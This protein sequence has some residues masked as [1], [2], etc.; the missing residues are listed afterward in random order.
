MAL[1]ASTFQLFSGIDGIIILEPRAHALLSPPLT[2][3]PP[4]L[5]LLQVNAALSPVLLLLKRLSSR[6]LILES[7][8]VAPP[9]PPTSPSP[10]PSDPSNSEELA[11]FL[12]VF[13]AER[14]LPMWQAQ[15]GRIGR[16]P[17]DVLEKLLDAMRDL[18][19]ALDDEATPLSPLGASGSLSRANA[20]GGADGRGPFY[21]AHNLME[22]LARDLTGAGP[23]RK[24]VV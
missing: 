4:S 10:S 2:T 9:K 13:L 3:F 24:S 15:A 6:Q 7:Q 1:M 14:L 18:L 23:D 8:F 21:A 19:R 11:R 12:H 22:A 20:R 16:L 17:A 5:P